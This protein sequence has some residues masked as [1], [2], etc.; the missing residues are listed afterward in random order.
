MPKGEKNSLPYRRA[1]IAESNRNRWKDGGCPEATRKKTSE[2]MKR[3]FEKRRQ[4]NE[5]GRRL[6]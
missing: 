1:Q 3:Y 5:N 4:E 2:S 6:C